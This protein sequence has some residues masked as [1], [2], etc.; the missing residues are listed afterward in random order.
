MDAGR[1]SLAASFQRLGAVNL[2]LLLGDHRSGFGV[3]FGIRRPHPDHER[4]FPDGI[5]VQATNV[6]LTLGHQ[7]ANV[8]LSRADVGAAPAR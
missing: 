8:I 7:V 5:L 6:G 4:I 3:A 1:S 2:G